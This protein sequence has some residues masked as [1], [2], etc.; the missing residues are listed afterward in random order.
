MH[1]KSESANDIRR[2]IVGCSDADAENTPMR[3]TG[4]SAATIA[5]R[6]NSF[7]ASATESSRNATEDSPRAISTYPITS[8]SMSISIRSGKNRKTNPALT[9][10]NPSLRP[11]FLFFFRS[12]SIV[13]S[14]RKNPYRRLFLRDFF[15]SYFSF[16]YSSSR[17]RAFSSFLSSAA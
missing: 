14:F 9:S 10:P 6:K 5:S 12:V 17:R 4:L 7:R 3:A 1:S 16:L 11:L 13:S 2:S 15:F 8:G